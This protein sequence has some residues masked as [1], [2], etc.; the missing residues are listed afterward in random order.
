MRLY[1]L[2]L[3]LTFITIV[4]IAQ[5][6][7]MYC[8]GALCDQAMPPPEY[9]MK[10][11]NGDLGEHLTYNRTAD[12][13]AYNLRFYNIPEVNSFLS[14]TDLQEK[15]PDYGSW[16]SSA[17]DKSLVVTK[18]TWQFDNWVSTDTKVI[19]QKYEQDVTVEVNYGLYDPIEGCTYKKPLYHHVFRKYNNYTC[20]VGYET[21][22]YAYGGE[23]DVPICTSSLSTF[24]IEYECHYPFS[25]NEDKICVTYCPPDK[26]QLDSDYG[27][28]RPY[29]DQLDTPECAEK[30]F[31]PIDV[32][33][34]EKQQKFSPDYRQS[35][36]FPLMFQ[37]N[38]GSQK[39]P[40]AKRQIFSGIGFNNSSWKKYTQPRNYTGPKNKFQVISEDAQP[41]IGHKQWRHNYQL[42]LFEALDSEVTITLADG[43]YRRFNVSGTTYS[44]DG[45]VGDKLVKNANQWVYYG[46][47]SKV[48]TF[49]LQG[50]LSQIEDSSGEHQLMSYDAN[51]L[52]L[53]VTHSNGDILS[54]EY[55]SNNLLSK[56]NAPNSQSYQYQYNAKF[57]LI[58]VTYPDNNTESY[59]YENSSFPYA[60]TGI[61]DAKNVRYATWQYDTSGRA[62]TSQHAGG[63]EAGTIE[64][65]ANG[66]SVKVTNSKGKEKTLG[67]VSGRL[68]TVTGETCDSTG[69]D[70][71][72]NYSYDYFGR[73]TLRKDEAGNN[74]S[75]TYNARGLL[76]SETTA[77]YT[78]DAQTTS[79]IYHDIYAIP[80][81]ITYPSG[82]V[83]DYSLGV[84]GR[85]ESVTQTVGT[86]SRIVTYSYNDDGL[87][88]AID[89]ALTG[90][91]DTTIFTYNANKRVS[92]ITNAL[93]QTTQFSDYDTFGNATKITEINGVVTNLTY[94]ARGR[95]TSAATSARVFTF[96]YDAIGQLTKATI[97]S[98]SSLSY[99]YDDARRLTQIT[100]ALGESVNFTHDSEG[101]VTKRE[102]KGADDNITN[103]Q[104][105][106]FDNINRLSQ[107]VN[108][109]S[110]IW[111]NTY[112]VAGNLT[113]QQTPAMTDIEQT[114]DQLKRATK[115]LDQA[116]STTDFEYNKLNQ[117]TKVTDALNRSTSYEY[118]GFGQR[119][120][121][122]SP[123]SGITA[124]TYDHVGNI[125]VR[126][127]ANSNLATYGYDV[128]NRITQVS[129]TD[130][131][132]NITFT[133]DSADV[134]RYGKGRL[135][136]VTDH[137]GSTEYYYNAYGEVT[138]E[139]RSLNAQPDNQSYTT[140][141]G[142]NADGQ[143][144]K[145]TYPSSRTV[146][147][148][149][150]L[151]GLITKV[152]TTKNSVTQTLASSISYLPFGPMKSL[153]Y[154]NSKTLTQSFNLDYQLTS[155]QVTGI[156]DKTYAYDVVSN[157]NKV[158]DNL[159]TSNLQ[160]FTYDAVERLTNASGAYGDLTYTYDAIGNRSEKTVNSVVDTYTYN[161]GK[162]TQTTQL[163]LIYDAM[164]NTTQRG[165]DSYVYNQAGRLSIA[166]INSTPYQYD[167]NF[168]GQRVMKNSGTDMRYYQYGLSGELLAEFDGSGNVQVEYIYL[169]GQRI[170]FVTDAIYY[171]DTNHID[172][173][174]ALT[175]QAGNLVWQASYTPFGKVDMTTDLLSEKLTARFPGQYFDEESGLHYNYFRDYDP[176]L[177]RYIQSDPRGITLDFSDPMRMIATSTGISAPSTSS[178][179][180]N[181]HLY[182][183]GNNSP[184]MYTDPTGE[185][186]P[187]AAI[188]WAGTHAWAV[189]DGYNS[190]KSYI[191]QKCK[192][193]AEG[194]YT[195]TALAGNT[196]ALVGGSGV[197]VAVDVALAVSA[198]G[199][200]KL[201]LGTA[202][203]IG[204][205]ALGSWLASND[206]D[207][208]C[209][210]N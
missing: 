52:L 194:A 37:R 96:E 85:I 94:D 137:S 127:D 187:F 195:P 32:A 119:T 47:D 26:P 20:S 181:N 110:K 133:Y 107:T 158:T 71:V 157:I 173:P 210:C 3:H 95:L 115:Q 54:F 44:P 118:N 146:D 50:Q 145:I 136:K 29:Q 184:M 142:Y 125:A 177:G 202:T 151:S 18:G 170:A 68:R 131:S 120:K 106:I 191:K 36:N 205:F 23:H 27:H 169:N 7:K 2:L 116:E 196:L 128:I 42:S 99:T 190:Y 63:V 140:E 97:P 192:K 14:G 147:Y 102:L 188:W 117:L 122:T 92:A 199:K 163:A 5:A 10:E 161:N 165:G 51:G 113:K 168:L 84:H 43:S 76:A 86:E 100:N 164:G 159:D 35:S 59:H 204:A 58:G 150:N 45:K 130:T 57:N 53:S 172:A 138:K 148:T 109:A 75:Y 31:N 197:Q 123:D 91:S 108:A 49:T 69:T 104:Q 64:Y 83:S 126:I 189:Y 78:E 175:N 46:T 60:L 72:T 82:L 185:F 160:D 103:T 209:G 39:A 124:F 38:Y 174:L 203:G 87:V 80:T 200:G 201:A 66:S 144:S 88:S 70:G 16:G 132:E 41:K 180:G 166:T 162:L 67:Y 101:N 55:D 114:F 8:F 17:C 182:N 74:T 13:G 207:S 206:V 21:I 73:K 65:S 167:Y 1:L 90:D 22:N 40:E 9:A 33:A 141:Y 129:Y 186:V 34:G 77:N 98:G 135:T 89:G 61:T 112:D 178:L 143:V 56:V 155:K 208:S 62:I 134:G 15:L 111:T 121:Q 171:V 193:K 93:A 176:E 28:C 48:Y 153:T 30:V 81:K 149:Y 11:A 198:S 19:S 25:L 154:G 12:Y 105:F 152:S 139:V 24:L 6:E 183:Y 4:N 79:Y 179:I 156:I